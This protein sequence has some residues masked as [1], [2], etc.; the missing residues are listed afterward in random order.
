MCNLCISALS[1]NIYYNNY[2]ATKIESKYNETYFSSN[3]GGLSSC[4]TDNYI[5]FTKSNYYINLN[6]NLYLYSKC[7]S[8]YESLSIIK[9]ILE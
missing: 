4:A 1:I 3:D 8:L 5:V 6:K 2:T 9:N 7:Y